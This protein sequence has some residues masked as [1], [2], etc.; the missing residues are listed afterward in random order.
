MAMVAD[1]GTLQRITKI[2][3]KG[4]AREMVRFNILNMPI[5]IF[6]YISNLC[7]SFNLFVLGVHLG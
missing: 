6:Y 3:G 4:M 7:I 1:I 5:C 2:V